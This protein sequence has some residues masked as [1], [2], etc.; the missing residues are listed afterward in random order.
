[1]P[2]TRI[3]FPL[4]RWSRTS[5]FCTLA[6]FVFSVTFV[7]GP[8]VQ[9]SPRDE[10]L[11]LVPAD[12]GFCLVI[13]DLRGHGKAFVE[14][15]FLKQF[16]KSPL[17]SKMMEGQELQ[18]LG[19]VDQ[20]LEQYLQVTA[21]Q[22]RDDILGDA[23]VLAYRPGPPDR[24]GEEQGLFMVR[25]RD[26]KLLGALVTRLNTLQKQSGDLKELQEQSYA[27]RKYFGRVESSGAKYYYLNG[28]V[29]VF[30][31]REDTLRQVIDLDQKTGGE[32]EPAVAKQLQ[33]LGVD[34]PLAALWVNP[35]A[36]DRHL[37][38]HAAAATGGPAQALSTLSRYWQALEGIAF[39]ADMQEDLELSVTVRARPEALPL[40]AQRFFKT[41]AA[42]SELWR[43]FPQNALLA[44]AGRTNMAA[45]TDMLSDFLT[46]EARKS[47]RATVAGSAG[48][49]FGQD[50][51]QEILPALGP[52]WGFC[53]VAPAADGK[54]WMPQITAAIRL[55]RGQATRP[56]DLTVLNGLNALAAMAVF[57]HNGG[58]PGPLSLR[59]MLQGQVEV[60]YVV[61]EKDFPPGLEPAFA[62][63]GGYLI[64]AG[65]PELIRRFPEPAVA[66][67]NV[68]GHGDFPLLRLSLTELALYLTERRATFV[69]LGARQN[70]CSE[71]EAGNRLDGLLAVL[72]FLD[73]LEISQRSDAGRLKLTLQLR[74]AKPLK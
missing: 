72:Q 66:A 43:H 11:R 63:K 30:S 52:D 4:C 27:G 39:T 51:V 55:E 64:F 44:I 3:S 34:R 26:A 46:D 47:A 49:V 50:V 57:H 22:L 20:F 16:L 21:Q 36:F 1:M 48:A 59:S 70:H 19:L 53:L 71:E 35:R 32:T 18:K 42:P 12:V 61:N 40:A 5:R 9:A 38:R 45:L 31:S 25:A 68:S 67:K 7:L 15:P 73:R 58:K 10:L 33:L 41:G 69:S 8:R 60:R 24:P 23:L 37:E 29:L 28:P 65:S 56:A 54:S 13:D 6:L 17:T 62:L 14:S 2:R 74:T